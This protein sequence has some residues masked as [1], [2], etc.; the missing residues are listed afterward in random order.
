M[1]NLSGDLT[2]RIAPE[3]AG[4]KTEVIKNNELF[5]VTLPDGSIPSGYQG[6]LGLY[7]RDTRFLS[8]LEFFINREKPILLSSG[9][10]YSHFYQGDLT[11][12]EVEL[13]SGEILPIQT[14]HFRNLRL[15]D[16]ALHQR[17]RVVNFNLYPVSFELSFKVGADYLDIFEI[18]GAKRPRRGELLQPVKKE[19]G[20]VFRYR[21]L[22]GFTRSTNVSWYPGP[23]E[24][25]SEGNDLVFSYF[26]ELQAKAALYFY[27][28]I[29][30]EIG[31]DTIVTVPD[32]PKD[33][34][35]EF[36]KTASRQEKAHRI[37]YESCTGFDSG[38]PHFDQ[39][40]NQALCDLRVLY[41]AYPKGHAIEAGVPWYA[42]VFGRDALITG[43]QTLMVNP[44]IC[45]E[46][47][48]FLAS[49][50]GK[51]IDPAREEEPGKIIH[52]L[53]RGEMANCKEILHTPYYGSIDATLWFVIV[54]GEFVTWTQDIEFLKEMQEPLV[55]A[56]D[57]CTKYADK[58]GDGYIEYKSSAPGGLQNQGWKDSWDGVP[59]PEG[60]PV[61]PPVALVEVQAYLYAAYRRASRMFSLFG[62]K[63]T[64]KVYEGKARQL[65]ANFRRDF[66][67]KKGGY[68]GLA[69]DGRK[70]LIPTMASNMG[71]ALFT[72]ILPPHTAKQLA[73]K[74]LSPEMFSRWGI[75]SLSRKERA[76]NP[77]S[78]HNG[79]VWPHE[80]SIIAFGLRRYNLLKELERL[81][82]AFFD[83]ALQFPY[84]RVP[85]VFCGF[86]RRPFSAPVRYP[87]SCEP[88]AWAAG[89]VFLLLQA[90]LG[91][92][93]TPEGLLI[94]KPIL[95]VGLQELHVSNLRV[96]NSRINIDFVKRGD[97]VFCVPVKKEGDI[98]IMIEA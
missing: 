66:F 82:R 53:R 12:P 38:R 9:V 52:E 56:L 7:Y 39:V 36:V 74:L 71:H 95:P 92:K 2:L 70:R 50:Q 8:C 14:I 77:V 18:R 76:Y 6:A 15:I 11:N 81:S 79:S 63:E 27:L 59:D 87:V 80:N 30:V 83:A 22:D 75:R 85:E 51:E 61:E 16:K 57:W 34:S 19:G 28:N 98:R 78:Y 10:R 86:G 21:G 43:W 20:V 96:H 65:S 58:D 42:T 41:T 5:L 17:F 44:D 3:R 45:R 90:C 88:Q 93:T 49:Y 91:L 62:E 4:E 73:A 13:V 69:L 33:F 46:T 1:T 31:K 40:L 94:Q 72:G 54:L 29:T 37:W 68:L 55:K 26:L 32:K 23:E 35:R 67:V 48:R 24:V 47:L 60:K 25:R 84:C 97:H 64:A 89:S